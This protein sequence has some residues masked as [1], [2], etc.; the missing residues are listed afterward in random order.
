MHT[1]WNHANINFVISPIISLN[2][3]LNLNLL[4][5]YLSC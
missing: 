1:S 4:P 5:V 3:L 2:P